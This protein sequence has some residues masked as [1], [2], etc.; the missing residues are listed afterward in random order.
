[1]PDSRLRV[2][3]TED[4]RT[5]AIV[6]ALGKRQSRQVELTLE[7]LDKLIGELG[8]ARGQMVEGQPC[9]KF[10]QKDMRISIAAN[11]TWHIEAVPPRG[12]I[13]SFYHPKFGPVGFTL[14][15]EQIAKVVSFLAQRFILHSG[16]SAEKH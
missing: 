2:R 14:P 15:G 7:E 12:A 10:D 16:P 11:T 8:D 5:V 3:V 1:M 13:L 6:P 9:P 4:R